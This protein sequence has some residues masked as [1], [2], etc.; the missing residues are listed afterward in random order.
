[1]SS[2]NSKFYF[3]PVLLLSG[4]SVEGTETS[5]DNINGMQ[6]FIL[7]RGS[8]SEYFFKK[9]IV[10]NPDFE[11]LDIH[12]VI[13]SAII[14]AYNSASK[15]LGDKLTT[16]I[17][18]NTMDALFH[19]PNKVDRMS[20]R[21]TLADTPPLVY[22]HKKSPTLIV[23]S[24]TNTFCVISKEKKYVETLLNTLKLNCEELNKVTKDF[25]LSLQRFLTAK[26]YQSFLL[27]KMEK[28][29]TF[30]IGTPRNSFE[31]EVIDVC[32]SVTNCFLSN[33]NVQFNEPSENFEYDVFINLPPRT[34]FII[35]PTNYETVK[36][37][38][39]GQKLATETLKSKVILATQDKAQRL[40][41]MSIVVANGFP[42]DTFSQLKTIADSRGVVLMN[43]K[44]YKEKLPTVICNA[45]LSS[46]SQRS[47]GR[48]SRFNLDASQFL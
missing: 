20:V 11:I 39:S 14:G 35:E 28:I 42:E 31:Q 1:M 30:E 9:T 40:R 25:G 36:E 8:D 26:D 18:S 24:Q 47:Y 7:E 3:E 45:I 43:E 44:D 13:S 12:S 17:S 29:N 38:I 27:S 21:R 37:E 41:A 16:I 6:E 32:A 33:V 4:S 10:D 34:K 19:F 46:L 23:P 15:K 2:L 5:D 22:L 48:I